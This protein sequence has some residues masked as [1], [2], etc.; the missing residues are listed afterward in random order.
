M[1]NI[2]SIS[3]LHELLGCEK[4]KHPL[5]SLIDLDKINPKEEYYNV[6]FSMNYYMISLK[7]NIDCELIY[8]KKYFDF[9][10][11]SL[12]FTAPGQMIAKGKI[13]EDNKTN[14]WMLCFHPDLIRGSS[15]WHKMSEYSFFEY[16]ANEALQLSDLEKEIIESIIKNIHMEYSGNL[17]MYSNDLIVSNLE[18]LLNYAKRFYGRQF[19]TRTAVIK[20]S[21]AKFEILLSEQCSV[22]S[23]EKAGMPS[24][25]GLA[26][27]MGYSPNY[28]SDMLKK[29]TG[30]TTQE[31]I[32][33]QVLELAKK[34]LITTNEPIYCIAYKLGFEQPSSF[35]KF[36]KIQ[37]G[38]SPTD[39]RKRYALFN[40]V[41]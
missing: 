10:E 41:V 40:N 17:D 29:E 6:S 1:I 23:I 28:L 21:I 20:E 15:L 12:I 39:F 3:F 34:L 14:G 25:K 22:E 36:F 31:Y 5:I 27:A 38:V 33:L 13:N 30:K 35:T 26:Q 18:V 7:N 4:P 11:G 16:D 2:D 8:G 24:V 37:L 19:I 32:K 9:D